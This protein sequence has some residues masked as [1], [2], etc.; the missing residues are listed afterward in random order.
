MSRREPDWIDI[1]CND[2]AREKR[3]YLGIILPEKLEPRERIGAL[4]C[5]L[6]AVREE[7]AGASY[8][9]GTRIFPE[10][11]RG[12]A[13]IVNKIWAAMPQ[14]SKKELMFLHY[15]WKE[16]YLTVLARELGIEIQRY[17]EL[18]A[19]VKEDLEKSLKLEGVSGSAETV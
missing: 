16:I 15:V 6:A 11:F 17:Y 7:G 4:R 5:T 2:W 10:V 8:A 18:Y 19:D 14:G 12:D 13:L 9:T 3:K 1:V